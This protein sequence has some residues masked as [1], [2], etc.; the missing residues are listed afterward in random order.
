MAP[1]SVAKNLRMQSGQLLINQ[2]QNF[3]GQ[4]AELITEI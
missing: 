2:K 3:T 4:L 1:L